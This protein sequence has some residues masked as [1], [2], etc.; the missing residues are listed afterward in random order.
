MQKPDHWKNKPKQLVFPKIIALRE[1]IIDA[2]RALTDVR[3]TRFCPFRSLDLRVGIEAI[4]G[5]RPI[6]LLERTI[7]RSL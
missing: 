6:P 3:E 7:R 5:M 2:F 4:E 1:Q